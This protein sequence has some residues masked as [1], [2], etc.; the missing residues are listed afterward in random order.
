M[1]GPEQGI[2]P[3]IRPPGYASGVSYGRLGPSRLILIKGGTP[4]PVFANGFYALPIH[5]TGDPTD[6][7]FS[8][9]WIGTH[10]SGAEAVA[11]MITANDDPQATTFIVQLYTQSVPT[12]WQ[13][14]G[15]INR[16]TWEQFNIACNTVDV[17]PGGFI[18]LRRI[19][20]WVDINKLTPTP[21][22]LPG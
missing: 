11:T 19:P 13:W 5:G 17:G 21:T 4:H 8:A 22:W 10:P 9:S 16:F 14:R 1:I 12:F 15:V 18:I 3:D 2:I 7:P 20:E 6:D